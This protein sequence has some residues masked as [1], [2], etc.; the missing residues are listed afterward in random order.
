MISLGSE[1]FQ[2]CPS[3][4]LFTHQSSHSYKSI[5]QIPW[6]RNCII[7]SKITVTW[8]VFCYSFSSSFLF[9]FFFYFS[10]PLL[11]PPLFFLSFLLLL[12]LPL[13]LSLKK[14]RCSH[15]LHQV[16]HIIVHHNQVLRYHDVDRLQHENIDMT[17]IIKV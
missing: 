10:L 7:V 4:N 13:F 6:R 2:V 5:T 16:I 17:C 14:R 15:P 11:L 8:G 3:C 9:Y 1:L 12:L